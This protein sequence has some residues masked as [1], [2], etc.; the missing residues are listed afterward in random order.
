MRLNEIQ[1]GARQGDRRW[2]PERRGGG[3][4]LDITQGSI[5]LVRSSCRPRRNGDHQEQHEQIRPSFGKRRVGDTRVFGECMPAFGVS[6]CRSP[7]N[8]RYTRLEEMV[9]EAFMVAVEDALHHRGRGQGTT[10]ESRRQASTLT[11]P[12]LRDQERRTP[13]TLLATQSHTM[14]FSMP[15]LAPAVAAILLT[16]LISVFG[17]EWRVRWRLRHI[18]IAN[19]KPGEWSDQPAIDRAQ[20]N[21]LEIMRKAYADVS[22]SPPPLGSRL[23]LLTLGPQYHGKPYQLISQVGRR[24][25]LPP[26][27]IDSVK[28]DPRFSASES[29]RNAFSINLPGFNGLLEPTEP[30]NPN[31][32]SAMCRGPVTQ[33][34]SAC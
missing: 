8:A 19:K 28:T 20:T 29:L 32:F 16:L 12:I 1:G 22:G 15:F 9:P 26:H 13:V 11:D 18:P 10:I 33:N 14:I 24:V 6:R 31:A 7:I 25:I 2:K 3:L 30:G 4:G 34:L 21:A 23:A 5:K 17:E 27:L